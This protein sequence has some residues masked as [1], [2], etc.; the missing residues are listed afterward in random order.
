MLVMVAAALAVATPTRTVADYPIAS[1]RHLADPAAMVYDG[2][3]Y[4]YC[5]N[6]DDSPLEGG[7]DMKSLVCVSSSDLKN[8]TDHGEVIRVPGAAS[9]AT[10]TW[11]PAAIERNGKFYLY[12]ANNGSNIGVAVSD[13]PAGPFVDPIGRPLVTANTPGVLP[14]QNIWVF[15]PAVF[16]DDDG[17]AYLYFGGNGEDN[18]RIIRLNEDMISVQGEAIK[19]SARAFFEAAW[20]H[21]R[22]DIY[23]LSYSTQPSAGI[24]IDYLTSDS[25]IGPFTYAGVVAAQPPS[26][27]NN[28]HAAEFEL[29]GAWY[30]VYHNRFVANEAGIP[31]VYRRNI[32]VEELHYEKDG[33]II[34]VAYTRDGVRQVGNLNP[35]LRVEAETLNEQSGI[36]TEICAEGG[37]NVT[38]LQAGDWIRVRG[39]DFGSAG[40][41]QVQ[42]RV[43]AAGAGGSIEFRLDAAD[44]PVIATVEVASTGGDQ[45]W[46]TVSSAVT[47]ATGVHD[48]YLRFEGA[49]EAL[50]N[51]NWWQFLPGAAPVVVTEP[52][53]LKVASGQR[54]GLWVETEVGAPVAYQWF[55]DNTP[56]AGATGA[57]LNLTEAAPADAGSY[58]VEL[59]NAAGTSSSGAATLTVQADV[60]AE[61]VNLSVRAPLAAGSTLIT[62]FA[63]QATDSN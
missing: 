10:H 4:I 46:S 60:D 14:A 29:H 50:F 32:A 59:T 33:S 57:T 22:D 15:D 25:A 17:Q 1:H 48:L 26:N 18:V 52:R 38:D 53:P 28:N 43:A 12:F 40:A 5:S 39:V 54:A 31:P 20:M 34:P 41:G 30:H 51:F 36:E 16:I 13:S 35:Y 23:Y 11:A 45:T 3:V 27:N 2:R 37:M 55:R 24:R 9:W 21:K 19:V 44:G 8:W 42:A 61:L 6:D 58:H 49:G 7:Y 56:I 47:G 62:G 63:L